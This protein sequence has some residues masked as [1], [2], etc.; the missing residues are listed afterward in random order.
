MKQ[1]KLSILFLLSVLLLSGCG[2]KDEFKKGEAL[3]EKGDEKSLVEARN[4]FTRYLS[5]NPGDGGAEKWI[6]KIDEKYIIVGK[7]SV[8]N[9]FEEGDIMKAYE[10]M[11]NLK[12]I[13]PNDSE[14]KKGF[15]TVEEVYKDQVALNEFNT[16]LEDV[17][18][19]NFEIYSQWDKITSEGVL[20]TKTTADIINYSKVAISDISAL[21]KKVENKSLQ[22]DN[23]VF[24]E[25]NSALFEYLNGVESSLSN[26]ATTSSEGLSPIDI[27]DQVLMLKPE[28][29]NSLYSGIKDSTD[30]YVNEV[31]ADGEKVRDITSSLTF[32]Y[33]VIV[34]RQEKELVEESTESKDEK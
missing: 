33:G 10:I 22:I 9:Y 1:Y 5:D 11:T 7:K 19:T 29:F 3:Y 26:V 32:D 14:I 12:T 6:E 27:K 31:D 18:K 30:N 4:F 28:P 34:K 15:E 13:A 20:G 24:S 2:N 16:Y 21:R 25:I 23:S 17:F 8:E